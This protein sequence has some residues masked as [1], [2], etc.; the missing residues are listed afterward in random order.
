MAG[1]VR[2]AVGRRCAGGAAL[3]P[4]GL[5]DRPFGVWEER[6]PAVRDNTPNGGDNCPSIV[7]NATIE[8]HRIPVTGRPG[9]LCE[10]GPGRISIAQCEP[11]SAE[12]ERK[13]RGLLAGRVAVRVRRSWPSCPASAKSR[14]R[15]F[16]P[17]RVAGQF[18]GDPVMSRAG[19]ATNTRCC[20]A[21]RRRSRRW[22][23]RMSSPS[24]SA[25]GTGSPSS[26]QNRLSWR[27]DISCHGAAREP[28][29]PEASSRCCLRQNASVSSWR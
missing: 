1:N 2:V 28:R 19:E 11:A 7:K 17:C 14:R 20:D 26:L 25:R 27:D 21:Y 23:G 15:A 29:G 8:P 24:S 9:W 4:G 5:S 10:P 6:G 12:E 3:V 18:L 16:L 22:D 13:N